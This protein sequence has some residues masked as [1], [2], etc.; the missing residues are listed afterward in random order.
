MLTKEDLLA[1]GELIKAENKGLNEAV[2]Q[3]RSG[4]VTKADLEANNKVI[5]T[6]VRAELANLKQEFV[7]LGEKISERL[8]AQD[9]KIEKIKNELHISKN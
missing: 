4:M 9:D 8:K 6:I 5:G 2:E 1:I 3:I 7:R